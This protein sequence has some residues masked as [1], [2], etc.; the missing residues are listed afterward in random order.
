M[1][2][3]NK[4]ADKTGYIEVTGNRT[5]LQKYLG[6]EFDVEAFVTNTYGYLGGKRLIT[7]IKVKEFYINHAWFKTE[8]VGNLKHGYQKLPIKITSYKDHIKNDIK[9][10]LQYIG[11][12]GKK[13]M[14]TALIKPKWMDDE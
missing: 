6:Q 11:T 7:E 14:N 1:K 12:K 5:E 10:G 13:Y 2:R 8:N 9:Y 4:Q 3:E